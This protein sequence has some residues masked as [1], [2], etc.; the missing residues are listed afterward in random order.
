MRTAR[1]NTTAGSTI[2]TDN[3]FMSETKHTPGPWKAIFTD[4]EEW[5]GVE[6]TN[7]EHGGGLIA[8]VYGTDEFPCVEAT[9]KI[10]QELAAN[11]R[12]IAAAPDYHEAAVSICARHD[13]KARRCN[14]DSCGCED[15]KPFRPIIAKATGKEN[16]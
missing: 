3:P 4:D 5:R 13:E 2:G 8:K 10:C 7:I 11:A 9:D 15:C 14:F 1:L 16:S 12:L 6:N